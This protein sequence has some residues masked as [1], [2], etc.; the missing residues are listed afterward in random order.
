MREALL[1]LAQDGLVDIY[2]QSDSFV[3]QI[4]LDQ[5]EE[6]QF[7][8]E[9][10][11]CGIIR[12]VSASIDRNSLAALRTLLNQQQD[13]CDE[14]DLER[15]HELD[16]A[17]H[18]TLCTIAG[19]PGVWRLIQRSK[20]HTDR[21]R[22][23]SLPIAEQVPRLIAQNRAIVEAAGR[24]S[25]DA[26]E[27]TLRAHLREVFATMSMPHLDKPANPGTPSA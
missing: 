20:A 8:R 25:A 23:L 12:R 1:R 4:S 9:Q 15:F 14:G 10:L 27:A 21:V 7:I 5:F 16:E 13:A 11:E 19:R 6:A 26:A 18:A 3:A 2:P 22:R 17:L 24:G